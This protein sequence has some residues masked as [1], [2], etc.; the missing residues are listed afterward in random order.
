MKLVQVFL[1]NLATVVVALVVYDQL[2]SEPPQGRAHA[3]LASPS[4]AHTP[5]RTR[6]RCAARLRAIPR[7]SPFGPLVRF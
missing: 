1:L 5:R 4:D 2:R 3:H 7:G 6:S